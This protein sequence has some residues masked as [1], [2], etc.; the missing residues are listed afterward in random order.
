VESTTCALCLTAAPLARS[1]RLRSRVLPDFSFAASQTA[2]TRRV[3]AGVPCRPTGSGHHP[4]RW[5][6]L[7][8][9][10]CFCSVPSSN[11]LFSRVWIMEFVGNKAVQAVCHGSSVGAAHRRCYGLKPVRPTGYWTGPPIKVCV[12]WASVCSIVK[13]VLQ[14]MAWPPLPRVGLIKLDRPLYHELCLS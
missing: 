12:F 5:I 11:L 2:P 9:A 13:F 7:P 4:L 3:R 14:P 1:L 8:P 10:L 6:T